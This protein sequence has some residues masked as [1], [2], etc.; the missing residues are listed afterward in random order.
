ML[1]ANG[2]SALDSPVPSALQPAAYASIV[3]VGVVIVIALP[4]VVLVSFLLM[5]LL[6]AITRTQTIRKWD[7]RAYF[8]VRVRKS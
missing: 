6:Y 2:L 3:G 4:F 5:P 8:F 1:V 7:S